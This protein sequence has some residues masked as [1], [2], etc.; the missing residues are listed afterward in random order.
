MLHTW[1]T[2]LSELLRTQLRQALRTSFE[3]LKHKMRGKV[4][5]LTDLQL[6]ACGIYIV[7]GPFASTVFCHWSSKFKANWRFF[8]FVLQT[9]VLFFFV[10][11]LTWFER[12]GSRSQQL[13]SFLSSH[14]CIHCLFCGRRM[15]HNVYVYDGLGFRARHCPTLPNEIKKT[16]L[17]IYTSPKLA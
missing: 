6:T 14:T 10:I 5:I 7:V 4:C 12:I 16:K 8:Y 9:P 11:E 2:N 1:R 13:L 3:A 15:A 17:Q